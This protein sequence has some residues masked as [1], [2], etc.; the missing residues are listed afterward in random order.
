MVGREGRQGKG[1][2]RKGMRKYR[3]PPSNCLYVVMYLNN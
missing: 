3:A 2:E 1:E